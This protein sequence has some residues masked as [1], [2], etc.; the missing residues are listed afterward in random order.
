MNFKIILFIVIT[1]VLSLLF[2]LKILKRTKS[3]INEI[4]EVASKTKEHLKKERDKKSSHLCE[5]CGMVIPAGEKDCP[6]CGAQI[7]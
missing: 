6:S 4:D 5:Y 3:T 2:A 1:I 7:K